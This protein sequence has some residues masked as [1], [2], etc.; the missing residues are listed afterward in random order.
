MFPQP[1]KRKLLNAAASTAKSL[2]QPVG[3]TWG[4]SRLAVKALLLLS[5]SFIGQSSLASLARLCVQ[6]DFSNC[7]NQEL[8]K[9]LTQ[10]IIAVATR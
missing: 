4:T 1:Q 10:S 5:G 8:R 6:L 3:Y 7:A 2:A 9:I